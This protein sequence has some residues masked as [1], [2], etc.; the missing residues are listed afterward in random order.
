[1]QISVRRIAPLSDREDAS[2]P[3]VYLVEFA[4]HVCD[5]PLPKLASTALDVFHSDVPI[6]VLDDFEF[7]VVHG[8]DTIVAQDPD[9]EDYSGSDDGA[10]RKISD[11]P[12]YFAALDA[13]NSGDDLDARFNPDG[14]GEHPIH[15][16]QTW[17][18]AVLARSTVRGYWD[19]AAAQIEEHSARMVLS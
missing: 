12:M 2:V 14:D 11:A 3:G 7:T 17:I 13:G 15:T 8:V 19:F 10:V 4:S 18:D 6:G 5:L 16:R 9:H 1:M